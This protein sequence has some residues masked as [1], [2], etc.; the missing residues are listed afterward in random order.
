MFGIAGP[1][2][3]GGEERVDGVIASTSCR[4]AVVGECRRSSA[5]SSVPDQPSA[6]GRGFTLASAIAGIASADRKARQEHQAA[7]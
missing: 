1:V 6:G 4:Y 2:R 5:P 7:T 3:A